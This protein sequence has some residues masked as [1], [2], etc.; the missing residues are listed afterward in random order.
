MYRWASARPLLTNLVGGVGMFSAAAILISALTLYASYRPYAQML[1]RFLAGGSVSRL[2]SIQMF[3]RIRYLPLGFI[4]YRTDLLRMYAWF[5]VIVL[6][7]AALLVIA[8]RHTR[9]RRIWTT[10]LSEL[11]SL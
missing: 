1:D 5:G 8:T 10:V 6:C 9:M 4:G 7:L 11:S 3:A 2:E